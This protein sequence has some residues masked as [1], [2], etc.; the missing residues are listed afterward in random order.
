MSLAPHLPS[1]G[2]AAERP[3]SIGMPCQLAPITPTCVEQRARN[4]KLDMRQPL[5]WAASCRLKSFARKVSH[6]GFVA[7]RRMHIFILVGV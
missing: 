4:K 2:V 5:L 3:Y 6:E 7:R 1:L